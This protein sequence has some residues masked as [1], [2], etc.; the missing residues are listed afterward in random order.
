MNQTENAA[1]AFGQQQASSMLNALAPPKQRESV[2]THI[3]ALNMAIDSA[4]K[5][6]SEL[7]QKLEFLLS[8]IPPAVPAAGMPKASTNSPVS[9]RIYEMT[10]NARRLCERIH[11]TNSRLDV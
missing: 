5:M 4:H 9:S 3:E 6:L 10:I 2:H 8:P 11:E 7:E 1:Y